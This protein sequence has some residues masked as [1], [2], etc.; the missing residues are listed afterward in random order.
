MWS[1]RAVWCVIGG[2]DVVGN[3][4]DEARYEREPVVVRVFERYANV[5][6]CA[7]SRSI[8]SG[9]IEGHMEA[10]GRF[11]R[12]WITRTTSPTELQEA[13]SF[14][15][16]SMPFPRGPG[17]SH[18]QRTERLNIYSKPGRQPS[19]GAQPGPRSM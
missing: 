6:L 18:T 14:I 16:L 15:P 1:W 13:N 5:G 10:A 11:I 8:T 3:G 17:H 12:R 19:C 7:A 2:S 4:I 9:V